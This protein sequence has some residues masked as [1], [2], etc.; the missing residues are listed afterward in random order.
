M[1]ERCK[2]TSWNQKCKRIQLH[3]LNPSKKT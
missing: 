2:N 1:K 3:E